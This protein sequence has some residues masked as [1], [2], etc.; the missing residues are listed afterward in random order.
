MRQR[1]FI[2]LAAALVFLLVGSV[3]VYAYDSSR[4]DQIAKGVRAGG[5][6]IGGMKTAAA[7]AKVRRELASRLNRPLYA[8]Y[9]DA[10]FGLTPEQ[11][12]FRIDVDSMVNEAL[13]KSR[14]GNVLSRTVRGVFGGKV[15]ANVPVES[16][17]SKAAVGTFV[18]RIERRLNRPAQDATVDFSTGELKRVKARK[19]R[20]VNAED[21]RQEVERGLSLPTRDQR[22]PVTVASTH[23]K[24]TTKELT[25]KYGTVVAINRGTYQLTLFKRLKRVKTY[26]IAVGQQGLE[27]PA[28]QYTVA[29]KQI[30]PYWHVPMRAWAGSLAGR[31]IPP[32]P[33][34]PLKAR[35]IGIIDGAGIHGTAD[36]GSLGSSA[37]H[38]CIRMAVPD[39]IELFNRTP[40]GS[41]I[42]IH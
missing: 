18:A 42:F 40:Y 9:H 31:V 11:L 27:T 17:Y 5:V 37:S 35:W 8:T 41:K 13:Q 24:V 2:T 16:S 19:G 39:V 20:H 1:S 26:T 36:I 23:P 34:N 28:G 10:R 14:G 6:D 32:G 3:A 15:H 25:S 29:D 30:N 22:V 21:L 4:E 7:R 38:G 33:Q 12:R